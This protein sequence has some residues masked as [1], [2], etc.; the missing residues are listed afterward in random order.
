ML[1]TD[2]TT[3]GIA[4]L[5]LADQKGS[6]AAAPLALPCLEGCRCPKG[7][8]LAHRALWWFRGITVFFK[9]DPQDPAVLAEPAWMVV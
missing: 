6:S 8:H 2:F 5:F 1:L 9:E 3:R 7:L 4:R